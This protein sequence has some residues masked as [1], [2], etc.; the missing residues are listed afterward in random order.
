ALE[1]GYEGAERGGGDHVGG[2]SPGFQ[3]HGHDDP[4]ALSVAVGVRE[5]ARPMFCTI[6]TWEPRVSAKQIAST[7]RS[8]DDVHALAEHAARWPGTRG[9]TRLLPARRGRLRTG[10]GLRAL[11]DEVVAAQPCRPHPVRGTW[12]PASSS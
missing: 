6:S 9:G 12:R 10:A 1:D 2:S 4:R 3:E 8:P 7:P 5:P 11:G